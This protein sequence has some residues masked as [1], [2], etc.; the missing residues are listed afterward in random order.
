MSR[1]N[2]RVSSRPSS[3]IR[4]PLSRPACR[5]QIPSAARTVLYPIASRNLI[6]AAFAYRSSPA[7]GRY[8]QPRH[9]AAHVS[10]ADKADCRHVG[11]QPRL[12]R[13]YGERSLRP[14]G[15]NRI[16]D[17]FANPPSPRLPTSAAAEPTLVQWRDLTPS[18]VNG[19]SLLVRHRVLRLF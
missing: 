16:G 18:L 12:R 5:P 11:G 7:S 14:T 13:R 4:E 15:A 2:D 6:T 3:V 9:G 19:S 17:S 8:S 1:S 10:S